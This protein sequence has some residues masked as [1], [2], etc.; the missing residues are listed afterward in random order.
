ML[1]RLTST[2][3]VTPHRDNLSSHRA[4]VSAGISTNVSTNISSNIRGSS[5][6]SCRLPLATHSSADYTHTSHHG[7]SSKTQQH[8]TDV[9]F[10]YSS[11]DV[12]QRVYLKRK[13]IYIA[14]SL[15]GMGG[16]YR[17]IHIMTRLRFDGNIIHGKSFHSV[18]TMANLLHIRFTTCTFHLIPESSGFQ[19]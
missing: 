6:D 9:A 8:P 5:T 16:R 2:A 18:L 14:P 17:H 15:Q 13:Y 12:L 10:T 3:A 7:N 1:S 11:S 19:N 4:P